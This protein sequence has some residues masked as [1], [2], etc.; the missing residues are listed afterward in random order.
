MINVHPFRCHR[1]AL[2]STEWSC[3]LFGVVLATA[4][5]F[6]CERPPP[7]DQPTNGSDPSSD[8]LQHEG[9]GKPSRQAS[10]DTFRL[11]RFYTAEGIG[12]SRI[13]P[14]SFIVDHNRVECVLG[15]SGK[16]ECK[17][18]RERI[19]IT[20]P[21]RSDST[22]VG[23]LAYAVTDGEDI[24]VVYSVSTGEVEWIRTARLDGKSLDAMWTTKIRVLRGGLPL[25]HDGVIYYTGGR[26]AGAVNART[27]D[28][29]WSHRQLRLDGLDFRPFEQPYVRQDTVYFEDDGRVLAIHTQ[30]GQ[31]RRN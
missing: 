3:L 1:K 11:N 28:L 13:Y 19:P 23:T 6:G 8:T 26:A 27:G 17:N 10:P 31:R 9:I 16:G 7:L 4:L 25:L 18:E 24:L 20:L 21:G 22:F 12:Q 29:V 15:R 2:A 5:L 30:T 14:D